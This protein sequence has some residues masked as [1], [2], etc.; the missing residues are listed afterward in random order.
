MSNVDLIYRSKRL[1]ARNALVVM[2]VLLVALAPAGALAMG[3]C[4]AMTGDCHGPCASYAWVAAAPPAVMA[5]ADVGTVAVTSL[6][7]QL[8]APF[9]S[10]DPPPRVHLSV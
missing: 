5:P 8:T 1:T 6:A 3:H 2:V 7:P 9:G 10:P 4:P